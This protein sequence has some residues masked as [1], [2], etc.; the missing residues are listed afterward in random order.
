MFVFVVFVVTGGGERVEFAAA[1]SCAI[2]GTW[3]W[4]LLLL[5]DDDGLWLWLLFLFLLMWWWW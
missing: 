3:A 4:R 1:A 5:C 2:Y